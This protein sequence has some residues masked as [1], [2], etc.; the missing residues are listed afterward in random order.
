MEAG[1]Y[2]VRMEGGAYLSWAAAVFFL[3]VAL[4]LIYEGWCF[5]NGHPPITFVVRAKAREHPFVA[6]CVCMA[7]GLLIG[8]F[9]WR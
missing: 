4:L 6:Y 9:G 5:W 7:L 8:H 1:N 2:F 3:G